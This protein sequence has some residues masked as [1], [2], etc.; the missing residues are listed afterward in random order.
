V[1][2]PAATNDV[3]RVPT[4]LCAAMAVESLTCV[5]KGGATTAAVPK[6][7]SDVP[8]ETP[9]SPL[10]MLPVPAA[11]TLVPPRMAKLVAEPTA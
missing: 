6:P 1:H 3:Y 2:G 4:E 11:V 8:G 7:V 9:T 10:M 5:E